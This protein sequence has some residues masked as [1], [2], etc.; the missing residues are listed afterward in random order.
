MNPSEIKQ[1]LT[2]EEIEMWGGDP[3][4]QR[5]AESLAETRRTLD[6]TREV[7]EDLVRAL[8]RC[9]GV[10]PLDVE[11]HICKVLDERHRNR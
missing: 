6:R 5:L 9:L 1:W 7:E 10:T 11:F 2:P 3:W 4:C 8:E